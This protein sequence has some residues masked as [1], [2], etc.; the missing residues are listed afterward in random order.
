MRKNKKGQSVIG[1]FLFV[2]IIFFFALFLGI[3]L[4]GFNIVNSVFDQDVDIGQVNLREI[5]DDTFGKINTGFINSA[6]TIG[7]IVVLG[8]CLIMILN[9]YLIGD[10]YPKLFF[11]IDVLILVFVF[12]VS[13]YLS[14]VYDIFINSSSIFDIYA[15]ELP[16]TS[17][18]MLNLPSVVG[19]LGALIMIFSYI[20]LR[21]DE[22]ESEVFGY[23][24]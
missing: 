14:Q 13:I 1:M 9:A 2:F 7:I 19:T 16:K 11:A 10:K 12:I 17:A 22:R 6:D 5:N 21:R 20:G 8:M 18:F 23:R 15:N 4:W 3:V 24:E